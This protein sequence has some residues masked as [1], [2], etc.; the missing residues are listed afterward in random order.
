M[1]N[2]VGGMQ[3]YNYIWG[4][5]ME[6]TLEL[7]CCKYPSRQDLPRYWRENKNSLLLYLGEVHRGVKGLVTDVNGNVVPNAVLKI[8]GR[9]ITFK[10]SKRGEFWR[11][12]MPG[13]YTIEVSA[14]GY[15]NVSQQFTVDDGRITLLNV[16]LSPTGFVSIQQSPKTRITN[17]VVEELD[18]HLNFKLNN[19]TE[20]PVF[21]KSTLSPNRD[22]HIAT[23]GSSMNYNNDQL[24]LSL[25]QESA[26]TANNGIF[27]ANGSASRLVTALG[28]LTT[29]CMIGI[30]CQSVY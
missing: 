6:I 9:E 17:R 27:M 12:L 24:G 18:F 26:R 22:K 1:F 7:S 3:D 2:S 16:Q 28:L 21:S 30:A 29:F 20:T 8:V 15:E 11:I 13:V 14:P 19:I 10:S 4:S 23:S 25:S 5:C